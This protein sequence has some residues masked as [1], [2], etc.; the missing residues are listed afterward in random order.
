MKIRISDIAEAAGV[1]PATVS[2]VFNGRKG[3][4]PAVQHKIIEIARDMGYTRET[5]E[6]GSYSCIRFVMAHKSGGIVMETPFFTSLVQGIEQECR[7]FGYELIIMSIDFNDPRHSELVDSITSDSRTPII[8]L[9]TEL[10][11]ESVL[12]FAAAKAPVV[13]LDRN[14]GDLGITSVTLNN[15]G[16]GML[17]AK[18]LIARGHR[19]IG[20]IGSAYPFQND[21]YRLAGLKIGLY[22]AGIELDEGNIMRVEPTIDGAY[23]DA[24]RYIGA[25]ERRLPTAYFCMNDLVAAG[26]IQA[27]EH[28][29]LKLPEDISLIGMDDIPICSVLRPALTSISV[30]KY[31]FGRLA[32]RQLLQIT[33]EPPEYPIVINTHLKITIRES[34][35]AVKEL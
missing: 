25:S 33:K 26:A 16:A 1:S 35:S 4:S 20:F 28:A 7:R 24:L 22:G 6:T 5:S 18:T 23:R 10:D 34:V 14:C 12:P 17:A 9:A 27:F 11:D 8:L 2:N 32:V 19:R 30:D 29:G 21:F 3:V 15:I 31:H 13:A